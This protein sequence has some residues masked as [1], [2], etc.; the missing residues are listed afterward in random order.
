MCGYNNKDGQL[1]ENVGKFSTKGLRHFRSVYI[2][3]NFD[4][5]HY[6]HGKRY[7]ITL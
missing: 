6:K 1:P 5:Y 2:F 4:N 7:N 3:I